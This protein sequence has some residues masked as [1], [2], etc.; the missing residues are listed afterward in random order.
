MGV[1][2]V[3]G[4]GLDQVNAGAVQ[5]IE[6]IGLP[7]LSG[8]ISNPLSLQGKDFQNMASFRFINGNRQ[9]GTCPYVGPQGMVVASGE[10][11]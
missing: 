4:H 5:V 11:G 6:Y 1:G 7:S 8:F 9:L 2:L 3:I 10:N